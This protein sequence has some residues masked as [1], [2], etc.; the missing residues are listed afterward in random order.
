MTERKFALNGNSLQERSRS[1]QIFEATQTQTAQRMRGGSDSSGRA[2]SS[3][4]MNCC[5][6]ALR[7]AVSQDEAKLAQQKAKGSRE[8]SLER[9]TGIR[10]PI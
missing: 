7:D 6:F 3:S 9:L 8:I 2:L 5:R 10:S 1:A 4:W